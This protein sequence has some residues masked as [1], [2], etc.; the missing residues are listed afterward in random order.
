MFCPVAD[1][2]G[3]SCKAP[4]QGN[5]STSRPMSAKRLVALFLLLIL[6]GALLGLPAL[7]I[8]AA[9]VFTLLSDNRAL[10]Q[11]WVLAHGPAV[12]LAFVLLYTACTAFS[13]PGGA[14]LTIVGGFLFGTWLAAAYVLVGATLG[15]TALFLIAKTALGDALRARAG[16]KLKAMEAGFNRNALSYMFVLRL[17][18][19]F[20]FWL[21]NL[22]PAF[23][24]VP[25]RIFVI[26]TFFGIMPGTVV[27]ASLGNGFDAV[28]HDCDALKAADATAHCA[29][30]ALGPVLMRADV[31]LPI[32]GLVLLA[33]LPVLY[34]AAR[35]RKA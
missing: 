19:L 27:F 13:V 7:G 9:Y 29:P 4:L 32:A 33:L 28:F 30:P 25:L 8:D 21:V 34:R 1:K 23:L 14:V 10:L 20:P 12:G 16:P 24:G 26:G 6:L 15:A 2:V 17:I 22:V 5:V 11:E 18:P 31:L 3:L 35:D